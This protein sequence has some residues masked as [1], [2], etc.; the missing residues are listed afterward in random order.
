VSVLSKG[1]FIWSLGM[2]Y[3][4]LA[5]KIT[6]G[7]AYNQETNRTNSKNYNLMANINIRF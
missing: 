1:A 3:F 6:G 2:N 5:N 7:L 4:S